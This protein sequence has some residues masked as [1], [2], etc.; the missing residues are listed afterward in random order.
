MAI[1]STAQNVTYAYDSAGNRI[2]RSITLSKSPAMEAE[3]TAVEDFV[4]ERTIKIYPN[5]T[6]GMLAVE[7]SDFTSDVKADFLLSDLS[8]KVIYRLKDASGYESIDLNSQ[9]AGVYVLR[10]TINGESTVWKI[11]KE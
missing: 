6:Q 2:S 5:P 1:P 4:A 3:E 9:S 11:I 7:I 10:I 8:G